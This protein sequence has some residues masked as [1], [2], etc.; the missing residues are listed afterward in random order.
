MCISL[1]NVCDGKKDCKKG[2][3]ENG[4]CGQCENFGC[5]E[6]CQNFPQGKTTLS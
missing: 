5:G 3:D 2:D 4:L 1:E 6:K